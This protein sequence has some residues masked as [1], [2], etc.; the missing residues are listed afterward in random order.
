MIESRAG[1]LDVGVRQ[2]T[3]AWLDVRTTAGK[4]H[5][6]LDATDGPEPSAETVDVGARTL[7]G[8]IVIRR[9]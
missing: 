9:P 3:A 6:Q 1:D 4:L 5:N 7:L 2:G 8:D